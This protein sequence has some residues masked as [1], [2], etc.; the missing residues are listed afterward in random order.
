MKGMRNMTTD[1]DDH[2]NIRSWQPAAPAV[3]WETL[4]RRMRNVAAGYS[5]CCE[6]TGTTRRLDREYEQIDNDAAALKDA[7]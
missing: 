3:D 1:R 6:E 2:G 4:Y 5:N 7:A